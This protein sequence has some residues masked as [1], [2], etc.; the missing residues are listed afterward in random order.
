M[1]LILTKLVGTL[2][3]AVLLTVAPAWAQLSKGS[4]PPIWDPELSA[5]M[6]RAGTGDRLLAFVHSRNPEL[7]RDAITRSGM[8]LIDSFDK[9]AVAVGVGTPA[10]I[11]KAASSFGVTYLEGDRPIEFNLLTSH[12]STRGNLALA[13]FEVSNTVSPPVDG[14]G[15][16]IAVVDEGIDGTHPMFNSGGTSK[17]V[18]NLKLVCAALAACTGPEGDANDSFFVDVTD[19]TNDSDTISLGGHGTHVAGIA[20]GYAVETADGRTLHGAAPGAKLVGISVGAVLSV[21]GGSAGLNWVLEHHGAPCGEGVP[22]SECPPIRVI[23]NSWGARGEYNPNSTTAKIVNKLISEGVSIAWSAGNS[24]GD[25]SNNAMGTESQSPTPGVISVANFDDGN[26]GT[27]DGDLHSTSSRGQ[28]G[29]HETYPDISAPGTDITSACRPYLAICSSGDLKD[30]NYGTIG[31]TSMA[32]PHVAGIIAQLLQADPTL[33]PAEIETVLKDTAY[34]FKNAVAYEDDPSNANWTH[35]YD[36]GHGL[37]DVA[38]AVAKVREMA[39]PDGASCVADGPVSIDAEDDA[40]AVFGIGTPADSEPSLDL[41]EGRLDWTEGIDAT[42]TVVSFKTRLKD[43]DIPDTDQGYYFNFSHDGR[44]WYVNA[45]TRAGGQYSLGRIDTIRR[46]VISGLEGEFDY[47]NDAITVKVSNADLARAN[48]ALSDQGL[49]PMPLWQ[50]GTVLS[51]FSLLTNREINLVAV[52]VTPVADEAG[53]LCPY[54]LGLGAVPA[55]PPPPTPPTPDA[56]LDADNPSYEWD[57]EPT[58]NSTEVLDCDAASGNGCESTYLQVTVPAGSTTTALDVLITTDL[59]AVN[60]FDFDVYGPSGNRI[61][62]SANLGTI[63]EHDNITI[64]ESG[65]YRIEVQA[66]LTAEATYHGVAELITGAE[67]PPAVEFDGEVTVSS[68]Y[69]WEGVAIPQPIFY[70]Q[71][72]FETFCDNEFIH[73]TV[74]SGGATLNVAITGDFSAAD[75]M[76]VHIYDP[77]GNRIGEA[78]FVNGTVEASAAVTVTGV[79]RV[80]VTSTTLIERYDGTASLVAA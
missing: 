44:P 15:I 62:G 41:L 17:V 16:T 48:L 33:T 54:T 66:Y 64:T 18:R 65:L 4:S 52:T 13:G 36:K 32:A 1:K 26:A 38:A 37:I 57:G 7:S 68:P 53:G 42:S 8:T 22:A 76:S 75:L 45:S 58:T 24:G 27:R 60:D 20:A 29:R 67:P 40:N 74:P 31:G 51:G 12:K 11:R 2:L 34:K 77:S 39:A 14:A 79:Y 46:G 21:Y 25:G 47:E 43:L 30:P 23:N 78:N 3:A 70:C 50:N 6:Q 10:Q 71:G 56:T 55:D 69:S 9:V 5:Q 61:G 73:V 59:G 63:D 28:S 72:G 19:S 35:S 49:Q 80:A